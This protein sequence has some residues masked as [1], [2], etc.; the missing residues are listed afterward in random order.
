M[1]EKINKGKSI[2]G[3]LSPKN[4]SAS[5]YLKM[6][7]DDRYDVNLNEKIYRLFSV[8]SAFSV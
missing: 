8:K 3:L 7:G 6:D 1:N 4:K 5:S 2:E